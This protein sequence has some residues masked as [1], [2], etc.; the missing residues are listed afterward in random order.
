MEQQLQLYEQALKLKS[1][2]PGVRSTPVDAAVT[3]R[4]PAPG[5]RLAAASPVAYAAIQAPVAIS[6][7]RAAAAASVREGEARLVGVPLSARR[8]QLC[9]SGP[10]PSSGSTATRQYASPAT[11]QYASPPPPGIT[12]E[13]PVGRNGSPE[14]VVGVHQ[15]AQ[16]VAQGGAKLSARVERDNGSH[17]V[18][19]GVDTTGTGKATFYYQGID[20]TGDGVPDALETRASQARQGGAIF[21]TQAVAAVAHCQSGGAALVPGHQVVAP[22]RGPRP[23]SAESLPA[24]T[25]AKWSAT[26]PT[27][28]WVGPVGTWSTP[29]RLGPLS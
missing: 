21:V 23:D 16:P 20:T 18:D 6:P 4:H 9:V 11:R 26:G 25:A 19:V 8:P 12:A 17:M 10:P 14:G 7:A 1:R 28:A 22:T 13:I 5:A 15:V 24:G 29:A 2:T 27:P 3:P